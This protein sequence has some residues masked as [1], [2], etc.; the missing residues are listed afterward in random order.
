M[1]AFSNYEETSSNLNSVINELEN[2]FTPITYK[3]KYDEQNRIVEENIYTSNTTISKSYTY[4][5]NN[6]ASIEDDTSLTSYSYND[7]GSV[8]SINT[9]NK[10][11]NQQST[12]SYQYD[13]FNRLIKTTN[14]QNIEEVTY[15]EDGNILTIVKT[16]NSQ[17]VSSKTFTYNLNKL[18][19]VTDS[20]DSSSNISITYNGFYPSSINNTA[21]SWEGKRLKQYGDIASYEY[22]SL[23]I[24][25]SKQVG[26]KH[27]NYFVEGDRVLAMD[28]YDGDLQYGFNLVF[29]YDESGKLISVSE[30]GYTFF[31]I[32]DGLGNIIK[33]VDEQGNDVVKYSYDSWG[34]VTINTISSLHPSARFNPFMYKGYIYD[35]ETGLYYCN[36]RYYNPKWGRFISPDSIEYLDPE[37]INGLNLYAY[38]MNDPIN[39]ADPSGHWVETVFDL[40]SLGVSIV[41]VIINPYDPLNWAGLAGDAL[42][43]IPFVTGV[44]ETVRGVKVVAK[45]VDIADDVYDTIKIMKVADLTDDAWDTVRGLDRAGDFTQSSMSAGRRIHK[46]YKFDLPGKEYGKIPGIRMDYF[47]KAGKHVYELKPYNI[48]SLKAGVSQ[49]SRYRRTMGKGY[50][51]ILELY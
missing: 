47:D 40:F 45:G 3:K 27:Y 12:V 16:S 2:A 23:G 39:Y 44:G 42:D 43:L 26:N 8:S 19:A 21:L 48:K 33:L 18:T 49:L 29:D 31:Y 4:N 5:I 30:P 38:C 46:G 28:I 34:K 36:S 37:S 15:D 14:G 41:E 51:W 17:Q 11:N 13:T 20:V 22:N 35:V 24:R 6:L 7:S 10:E 32:R 25:T 9:L 50:T 1:F